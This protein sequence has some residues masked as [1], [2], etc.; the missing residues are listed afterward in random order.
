MELVTGRRVRHAGGTGSACTCLA[1]RLA[2]GSRSVLGRTEVEGVRLAVS[3]C[4]R[5]ERSASAVTRTAGRNHIMGDDFEARTGKGSGPLYEAQRDA[6]YSLTR[7]ANYIHRF[8]PNKRE[9][10]T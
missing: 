4:C 1:V 10:E 2:V 7:H 3:N 8:S 6:Q 5:A 9:V